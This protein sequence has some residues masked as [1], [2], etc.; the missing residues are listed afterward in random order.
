MGKGAYKHAFGVLTSTDLLVAGLM[1]SQ[2]VEN[3]RKLAYIFY[4]FT[5]IVEA[6][7]G[8]DVIP[9]LVELNRKTA[10]N[11]PGIL[12]AIAAPNPL[13]FGIARN[14]QTFAA[15]LGWHAQVFRERRVAIAWLLQEL[16][17]EKKTS[18]FLAEFPSLKPPS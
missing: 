12:A 11:S 1:Q 2:D 18:S 16:A 9:Q 7:V 14:W 15:D 13:I 17:H 3:T 10:S 8:P 6:R 5:D 4:D